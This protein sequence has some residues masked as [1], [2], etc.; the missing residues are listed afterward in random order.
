MNTLNQQIMDVNDLLFQNRNKAYGSY[1][2]RKAYDGHLLKSGGIASIL[3]TSSFLFF[4]FVQKPYL[5]T[6]SASTFCSLP[7]DIPPPLPPPPPPKPRP[8]LR[9][10]RLNVPTIMFLPPIVKKEDL[11]I[12][13]ILP[14]THDEMKDIK[15]SYE[16]IEGERTAKEGIKEPIPP[17]PPEASIKYPTEVPSFFMP[18]HLPQFP[19]GEKAM[20]KYLA[21]KLR[22][23]SKARAQDIQGTVLIHFTVDTEGNIINVRVKK[24]LSSECDAEAMRV[25]QGMPKWT[26]ARSS[27]RTVNADF[28]IPIT[29]KLED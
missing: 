24:R 19:T 13:E 1:A 18:Q 3:F 11:I 28:T 10:L 17:P 15:I 22:Y 21:E 7:F 20:L 16:T 2:L 9:T 12:N 23:P 14:P 26:P 29:F 5:P 4:Q 25:V 27:G 6:I 8:R